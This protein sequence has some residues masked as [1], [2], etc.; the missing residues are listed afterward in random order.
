VNSDVEPPPDAPKKKA[1]TTTTSSDPLERALY[2]A[3][4]LQRLV[5]IETGDDFATLFRR[6]KDGT[7][8]NVNVPFRPWLLSTEERVLPECEIKLLS[9]EGYKYHVLFDNW[10][11]FIKGR[12]ILSDERR[13]F[14]S[15]GS[16]QKQFLLGTGRT[17]FKQMAFSDVVRMQIDIETTA[18]RTSEPGA[19]I[20]MIACSDNQGN[21]EM[22]LGEEKTMLEQLNQLV[23]AW[24]P[25]IIEG[26]N[27]YGFDLPWLRDRAAVHGLKMLWGRDGSEVGVG[28]ER[29]CAIGANARPFVPHYI[30]GRHLLD[31][32]FQTQRFD[33]AKGDI[34]RYGLKECA[35]HYHI[36]EENRVYLDRSQIFS[37]YQSDP[38]HV[39]AYALADVRETRRLSEIVSPTEFYQTQMVP[40]VFQSVAVTGSGEKINSIFVRAYLQSDQ[41]VTRQQASRPYGG[42]YTEMRVAG[43]LRHIVKADVESLYPSIMLSRG[44]T[45]ASDTLDLFLPLLKELTKRRLVAKKKAKEYENGGDL[46]QSAYWDGLQGSYKLLINSFYGY[47]GA[48]FYFND[49]AAAS[50]VTEIGQEIVKQIASDLEEAG[51]IVIEIDTDGVYFQPPT[52][53]SG[54]EDEEKFVAHIGTK[55]PDGIRLAFDGRYEVMLSLKAKNYVLVD[56]KGKTTFKG[57]SLR[58][59]ADEE[60]GRKFM[61]RS[62]DLLIAGE[63][64]TLSDYYQELLASLENRTLGIE[65]IQ[66]RERITDKTFSSDAK[67][68]SAEAAK[69]LKEGDYILLYQR[70]DG[71]LVPSL[72]YNADEDVE[73]YQT[74]LHKFAERLRAA[75]GEDK[76]DTLFPKPLTGAKRKAAEDAKQ[77]MSLFD[78]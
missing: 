33:L 15:Y 12:R 77:Q 52:G 26:H 34:S 38:E 17:L 1:K 45:S 2:G 16:P 43:L 4:T 9:G 69:G 70:E 23:Q 24:N 59:R 7:V 22:L 46:Y 18:L 60:F 57:S 55:L 71:A 19:M 39:K 58:S 51:A 75:V 35:K 54:P 36:A 5:A 28:K 74:K 40:D 6:E 31:T 68:R 29:N 61:T 67:K 63:T 41:A 65:E 48:P 11:A 49:Y 47:L 66:R 42:G 73:Y 64:Q 10:R 27:F 32:M 62:V 14:L 3:D 21:E 76:F 56:Y 25:D 13:E 53:I 30:W 8:K 72:N 78:V 20:F 37:L 50:K 44:V